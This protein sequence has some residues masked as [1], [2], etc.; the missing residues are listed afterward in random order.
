MNYKEKL[1]EIRALVFGKEEKLAEEAPME[2]EAAPSEEAP[3]PV[4]VTAEQFSAMKDEMESFKSDTMEILSKLT[5][6][7]NSTEKNKVPTEMAEEPKEEVELKEEVKEEVIEEKVEELSA[8]KGGEALIHDPEGLVSNR[9][10][11][12]LA[13]GRK[14]TTED[15]V[16]EALANAGVWNQG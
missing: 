15:I 13:A 7:I 16:F 11:T 8:P 3:K 10:K 14:K 2:Q 12:K 4:Y 6:M 9:V 1:D 5:E